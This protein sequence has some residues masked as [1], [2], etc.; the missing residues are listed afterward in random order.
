MDGLV[1]IK[2]REIETVEEGKIAREKDMKHDKAKDSVNG[3]NGAFDGAAGRGFHAD[4]STEG[5][6]SVHMSGKEGG[7]G[8]LQYSFRV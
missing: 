3:V 6:G 4:T 2:E 7:N 8:T 1:E 5:Q